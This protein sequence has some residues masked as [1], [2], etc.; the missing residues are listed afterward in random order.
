LD[1]PIHLD[2][3]ILL[4][5]P[6][7]LDMLIPLVIIILLDIP[8]HCMDT[9]MATLMAM[10]IAMDMERER[11]N[12]LLIQRLYLKLMLMPTMDIMAMAMLL[13]PMATAIATE[14]MATLH[15]AMDMDLVTYMDTVTLMDTTMDMVMDMTCM[16]TMV[17]LERGL[18]K[19][20][21]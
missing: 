9:L 2:I 3:H 15:M 21:N 17:T 1:T 5:T 6:I 4:D 18:L 16:V 20:I 11:Q 13:T 10:L 7:P 14:F 8:T 12:P 19:N